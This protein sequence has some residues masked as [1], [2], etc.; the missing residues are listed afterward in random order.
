MTDSSP[1]PIEELVRQTLLRIGEDPEREGL[2][3]TPSRVAESYTK[4]CW[5]VQR[6]NPPS[7]L[8]S[9]P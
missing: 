2:L 9:Y 5:A 7:N 4:L 8:P 6:L 1:L 3:K